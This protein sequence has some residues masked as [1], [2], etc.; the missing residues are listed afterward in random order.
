MKHTAV[1][2]HTFPSAVIATSPTETEAASIPLAN[3]NYQLTATVQVTGALTLDP[4]Q[5][6]PSTEV[7]C[8]MGDP[9]QQG[10]DDERT[11][12]I[13]A[14]EDFRGEYHDEHVIPLV[15]ATPV[16]S[17]SVVIRCSFT[18]AYA[19]NPATIDEVSVVAM[20]VDNIG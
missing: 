7:S 4:N 12:R 20:R 18:G 5:S 19:V 14:T 10:G 1:R 2:V 17:G 9:G 16:T 8:W 3:G 6:N 15:F 13:S 11:R